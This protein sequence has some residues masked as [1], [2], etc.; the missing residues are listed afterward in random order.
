MHAGH[1]ADIHDSVANNN[2]VCVLLIF[3][4]IF[5]IRVYALPR[6]YMYVRL[7]FPINAEL[8][9]MLMVYAVAR[10]GMGWSV[11]SMWWKK[12]QQAAASSLIIRG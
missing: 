12:Q 1:K 5:I 8:S 2:V 4:H 10:D 11:C 3:D 9:L 6:V 7:E